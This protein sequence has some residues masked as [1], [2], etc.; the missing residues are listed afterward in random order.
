MKFVGPAFWMMDP[1]C[2]TGGLP[3]Q[4]TVFPYLLCVL[5]VLLAFPV[6]ARPEVAA[7]PGTLI[8]TIIDVRAQQPAAG[9]VVIATSPTLSGERSART[10]EQGHYRLQR[11]PPGTY[12]L[13]F[14]HPDY[15]ACAREEIQ[16]RAARTVRLE[17]ELL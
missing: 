13:R 16:L 9:V 11:L 1:S 3:M 10:D 14:E 2:V 6:L 8:G 5:V 15:E 12:T 4:F 17:V 7:R